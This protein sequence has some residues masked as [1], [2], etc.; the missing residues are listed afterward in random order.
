MNGVMRVRGLIFTWDMIRLRVKAIL[1]TSIC[2]RTGTST[3]VRRDADDKH[4]EQEP[5]F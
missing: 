5:K 1:G 2:A 4:E 3:T